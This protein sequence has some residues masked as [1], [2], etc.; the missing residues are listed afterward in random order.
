MVVVG[1]YVTGIT[2]VHITGN[3]TENI[4]GRKAPAVFVITTLDLI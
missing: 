1:G 3:P 4:P 2:V